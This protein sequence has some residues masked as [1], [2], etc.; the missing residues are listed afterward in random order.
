MESHK[1]Y[2]KAIRRWGL[3]PQINMMIEECAE[4]IVELQKR[5]RNKNGSTASDII[6]EL[7]DVEIL[8]EQMKL[9]YDYRH[10]STLSRFQVIKIRKLK[11]LERMLENDLISR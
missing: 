7:V 5:N 9:I 3:E 8:L 2:K 4:L 1:L 10:S 6:E 11:R